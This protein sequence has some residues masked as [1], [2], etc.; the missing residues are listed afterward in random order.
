M[1]TIINTSIQYSKLPLDAGQYIQEALMMVNREGDYSPGQDDDKNTRLYN[2]IYLRAIESLLNQ[3]SIPQLRKRF[4]PE[5]IVEGYGPLPNDF[6]CVYQFVNLFK[7]LEI[8]GIMQIC[9]KA[10]QEINYVAMPQSIGALPYLC[11]NALQDRFLAN[12]K[13]IDAEFMSK[14]PVLEMNAN[15]SISKWIAE[16]DQHNNQEYKNNYGHRTYYTNG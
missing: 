4:T 10:G 12:C 15:N 2:L 16:A 13:G 9:G 5:D 1:A 6:L 3:K 14:M 11:R 8:N 7:T